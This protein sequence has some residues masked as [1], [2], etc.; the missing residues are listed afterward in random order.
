MLRQL[1]NDEAG[2]IVSAELVL[3]ATI[4]V[5]GLIVGLSEVQHAINTELND[6]ADAIGSLNQS[7]YVSGFHKDSDFGRG[8]HAF[9]RGSA[10]ADV[11]DDCDNNQCDITCDA[12]QPEGPKRIRR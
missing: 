8:V 5:I 11:T 1:L 4:L 9:T 2:F 6:V 12:P 10:F 7:Y 3:V